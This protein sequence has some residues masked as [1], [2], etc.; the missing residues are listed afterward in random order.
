MNGL[1]RMILRVLPLLCAMGLALD[2][3]AYN[4]TG[5]FDTI[6]MTV[7]SPAFDKLVLAVDGGT[8]SEREKQLIIACSQLPDMSNEFDAIVTFSDLSVWHTVKW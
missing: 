7:G 4:T 3:Q 6:A 1:M 5:H 2:A 8:V